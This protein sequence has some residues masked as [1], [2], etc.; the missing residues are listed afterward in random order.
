[1]KILAKILMALSILFFIWVGISTMEVLSKNT[2]RNP[3]YS[4]FNYW[5]ICLHEEEI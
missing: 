5:E 2:L 1:M 4:A 3:T